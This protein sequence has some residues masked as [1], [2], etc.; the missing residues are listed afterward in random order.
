MSD[1]SQDKRLAPW[2]FER[3]LTSAATAQASFEDEQLS[4]LQRAQRFLHVYPTVVPFVVLLLGLLLGVTV[5]FER[6]A[7][8]RRHRSFGRRGDGDFV[9]GDGA[10]RRHRR[11]ADHTG[12]SAW[13][14]VRGGAISRLC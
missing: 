5:D 1:A 6:F 3:V 8:G 12:L 9:G 2:E 4:I 14:V 10:A 11:M 13:S 7:T